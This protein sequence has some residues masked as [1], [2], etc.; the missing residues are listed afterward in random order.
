MFESG[1]WLWRW[2][3]DQPPFIEVGIGMVFVL[4]LAPGVLAVVAL[5]FARLERLAEGVAVGRSITSFLAQMVCGR[6]STSKSAV[7][8]RSTARPSPKT[9]GTNELLAGIGSNFAAHSSV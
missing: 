1:S 8:T 2:L 3:A 5:L 6:D 7:T 4:V 9:R